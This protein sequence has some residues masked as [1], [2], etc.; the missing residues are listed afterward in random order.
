M[1]F[2]DIAGIA[3]TILANATPQRGSERVVEGPLPKDLI[4]SVENSGPDRTVMLTEDKGGQY[5]SG[6]KLLHRRQH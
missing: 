2:A 3:Q 6:M 1:V 4:A 5:I